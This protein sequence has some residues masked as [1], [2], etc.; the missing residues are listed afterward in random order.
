[1]PAVKTILAPVASAES[2]ALS[3]ETAFLLA[4]DFGSHV[5]ALHVRPDAANL[6]PIV[7]E[8]VSG[9]MVEDM[10]ESAEHEAIDRAGAT[11]QEFERLCAVHGIATLDAPPPGHRPAGPSA[12]W[13]ETVGREEEAVALAGRTHDLTILPRPHRDGWEPSM[14]TINGALLESGRPVLLVPPRPA[15]PTGRRIAIAW[16]GSI[17]AAR[18]VAAAMPFLPGAEMVAILVNAGEDEAAAG[19]LSSYLA[20]H[21]IDAAVCP[22]ANG[23][24]F[25][26]T[27]LAKAEALRADLLIMGA[28]THSRLRQFIVGGV[29]R[30]VLDHAALPVLL[31]H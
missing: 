13:R 20:W 24:A 11:R 28:Y 21:A 25:G 23:G 30:H 29:T 14:M 1:M 22:V 17:E 10:V 3:L 27:L 16:N 15:A 26:K 2:A 8:G 5:T 31:C 4:R 9:A 7:G 12:A 18:A 6:M 19:D